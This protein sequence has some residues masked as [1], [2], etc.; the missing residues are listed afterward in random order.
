[1]AAF[2]IVDRIEN[3]IAVLEAKDKTHLDVPLSLFSKGV[4]EGDVVVLCDDGTYK[5]DEMKTKARKAK[6]FEMQEKIFG[7]S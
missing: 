3:N 5:T 2:W 4:K 6:L 1:M 7:E